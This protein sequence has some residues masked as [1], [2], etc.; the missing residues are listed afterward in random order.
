MHYCCK[1]MMHSFFMMTIMKVLVAGKRYI[2]V[3]EANKETVFVP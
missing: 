1:V 2:Q 3:P